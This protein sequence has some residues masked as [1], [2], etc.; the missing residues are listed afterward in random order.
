[1][2]LATATEMREL[3][4]R[5]IEDFGIPGAVLMENAGYALADEV[6]SS[7]D[8]VDGRRVVIICGRGNN[9]GDGLV[10]ARHL[11]NWG[12]KVKVWL[13][14]DQMKGDAGLN[15][16]IARRM[17]VEAAVITDELGGL[18]S[19]IKHAHAVVDAIFGTGLSNGIT[20][21][22]A[23]VI[24]I[25][26]NYSKLTL[27]ADM[28]SGVNSDD[29]QV[30]GVAV[31]ASSTVVFGL[32]KLGLYIYP[33][34]GLAGKI[35]VEDIGIPASA[36]KDAGIRATLV[37]AEHAASLLPGRLPDANKG[38]F[39]HLFVL[40]GSPGMTGAASMTARAATRSGA[41][42]VTVG[43]AEGLIGIIGA[44]LTEEMSAGLPQAEDGSLSHA[45]LDGI[46]SLCKK[47]TAA[48]IG[49]G[50]GTGEDTGRLVSALIPELE[51]PMV[52]DAAG[53][54]IIS[55]DV[56]VFKR[57]KA[58]AVL[59]PHPGEMAR[60]LGKTAQEIQ[61]DRVGAA[62]ELA[63]RTGAVAVLKGANTVTALP[64]G[65]VYINPAA[66]PG[67]ATG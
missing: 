31:K 26:N 33:G 8:G 32:P 21:L 34:A 19:D 25:I 50:L 37:T 28:P 14:S 4:R 48:A 35:T 43:V 20:G 30:M 17:G 2:K 51:I 46:L 11:F 59:T 23:A 45:A 18:S 66:N 56:S 42:L 9:G 67:M 12:A 64:D 39:G 22:P 38:N 52:I 5:A 40:A 3:D 36:V 29:G 65:N 62:R 63:G 55:T 60:L 6:E 13:F 61:N 44:K 41:G 27:S 16:S 24:E 53:L 10:A 58:E 49:P 57:A 47:K 1:M 7:L 15:L 54:N